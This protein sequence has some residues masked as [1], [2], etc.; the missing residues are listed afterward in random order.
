[1]Q[2][3]V[4]MNI[5][6]T[7]RDFLL[8]QYLEGFTSSKSLPELKMDWKRHYLEGISQKVCKQEVKNILYYFFFL[9]SHERTVCSCFT[10]GKRFIVLT[11]HHLQNQDLHWFNYWRGLELS[12]LSKNAL[13][14]YVLV[15]SSFSSR[16]TT[17]RTQKAI[18]LK[19]QDGIQLNLVAVKPLGLITFIVRRKLF[20][21]PAQVQTK[22]ENSCQVFTLFRFKL[23]LWKCY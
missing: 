10:L 13:F 1:M 15:Y 7:L 11:F 4:L 5:N 17:K 18:S 19:Y 6:C 22:T 8:G 9:M 12:F 21:E 23:S 2:C 14:Y 3:T 20:P 16:W